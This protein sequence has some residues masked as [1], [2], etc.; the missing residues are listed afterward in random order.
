M[1]LLFFC[2]VLL[3]S[4]IL[5]ADSSV[6][7]IQTGDGGV[8]LFSI[9]RNDRYAEISVFN[10]SIYFDLRRLESDFARVRTLLYHIL[11]KISAS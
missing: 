10:R 2:F 3:I 6:N 7:S 8:R 4:G 11:D 5:L 9:T 1:T